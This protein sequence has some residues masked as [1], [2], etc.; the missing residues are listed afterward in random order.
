M[1][2][3]T[4]LMR[5]ASRLRVLQA[6]GDRRGQESCD[7]LLASLGL[8]GEA[9][10]AVDNGAPEGALGVIV[11]RLHTRDCSE[12]PQC[13]PELEQ[14]SGHTSAVLCYALSRL[15]NRSTSSARST[16]STAAT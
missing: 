5:Y 7:A 14:A 3:E 10:L 6:T 11:D 1:Q 2:A 4:S 15:I 9:E 12:P 8:A 16:P 13:W